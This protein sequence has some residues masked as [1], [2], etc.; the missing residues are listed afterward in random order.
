MTCSTRSAPGTSRSATL[1]GG[2][3]PGLGGSDGIPDLGGGTS[4]GGGGGGGGGGSSDA[5][6][7]CIQ[8]ANSPS[9]IANCANETQ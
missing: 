5:Y 6:L 3:I 1:G 7:N 4:G 8:S 9:E 2:S